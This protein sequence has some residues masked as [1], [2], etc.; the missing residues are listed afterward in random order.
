MGTIISSR[1]DRRVLWRSSFERAGLRPS[2]PD[3]HDPPRSYSTIPC[4]ENWRYLPRGLRNP[5]VRAAEAIRNAADLYHPQFTQDYD[6]VLAQA[7]HAI[8]GE[9]PRETGSPW[10]RCWR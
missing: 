9:F 6:Q 3:M 2:V 4:K 8:A 1:C 5:Q 10:T 7:P